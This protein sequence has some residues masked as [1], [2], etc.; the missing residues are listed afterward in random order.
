VDVGLLEMLP[1]RV[2][3]WRVAVLDVGMVVLVLVLGQLMFPALP[4]PQ[5]VRHMEV[6]VVVHG[7]FVPVLLHFAYASSVTAG[8][9]MIWSGCSRAVLSWAR[10]PAPVAPSSAR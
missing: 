3:V 5:I 10:N 4:M 2:R 1:I 6:F 9:A 7:G 8:Q